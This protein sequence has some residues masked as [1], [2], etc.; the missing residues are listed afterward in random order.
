MYYNFVRHAYGFEVRQNGKDSSYASGISHEKAILTKSIHDNLSTFLFCGLCKK[1]WI[2]FQTIS[3]GFL[4]GVLELNNTSLGKHPKLAASLFRK[5]PRT[6][7]E[8]V[9]VFCR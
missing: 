5:G 2:G 4:E 8:A 9:K 3:V 7:C 6:S 1:S